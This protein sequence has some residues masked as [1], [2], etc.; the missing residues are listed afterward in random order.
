LSDYDGKELPV[1]SV[2][3]L[4]DRLLINEGIQL[5]LDSLNWHAFWLNTDFTRANS[6]TIIIVELV[7]KVKER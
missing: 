2:A 3:D 4:P 1:L 6:H 7:N 5:V